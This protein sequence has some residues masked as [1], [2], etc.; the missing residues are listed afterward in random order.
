MSLI[1]GTPWAFG[2]ECDGQWYTGSGWALTKKGAI[3]KTRKAIEAAKKDRREQDLRR[4]AYLQIVMPSS[5]PE[6]AVAHENRYGE[7][8]RALKKKLGVVD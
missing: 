5:S 6:Q 2:F 7:E 3:R 1:H 4:L 8:Y